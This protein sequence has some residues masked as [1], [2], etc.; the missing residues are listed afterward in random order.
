[1]KKRQKILTT[2]TPT[3]VLWAMVVR[4]FTPP[5]IFILVVEWLKYQYVRLDL[6]VQYVILPRRHDDWDKSYQ[7][8][9]IYTTTDT[10]K[11]AHM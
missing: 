8:R 10:C 2:E 9:I 1:M 5:A 7:L 6:Y 3:D 11:D 4:L